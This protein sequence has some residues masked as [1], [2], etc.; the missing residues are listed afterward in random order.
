MYNIYIHSLLLCHTYVHIVY[1]LNDKLIIKKEKK[2]FVCLF[3]RVEKKG[4]E[5]SKLGLVTQRTIYIP[6]LIFSFHR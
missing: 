4:Q 5:K 1:K 3:I 2:K 6:Y